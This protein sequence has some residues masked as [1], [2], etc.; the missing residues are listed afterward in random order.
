M[1]VATVM[2]RFQQTTA[3]TERIHTISEDEWR[4]SPKKRV[5]RWLQ[6]CKRKTHNPLP[7]MSVNQSLHHVIIGLP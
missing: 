4:S 1:Y 6:A 2:K 3:Q 7:D 5:R